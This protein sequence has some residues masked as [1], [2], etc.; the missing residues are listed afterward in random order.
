MQTLFAITEMKA[1]NDAE[2]CERIFEHFQKEF[3]PDKNLA[4]FAREI[5]Q[6]V[7]KNRADLDSDLQ[8]FAPRWPLKKLSSIDRVVLEIGAWEIVFAS[9]TPI[10]VILNE[11]IEIAKSFGD[12]S[13]GKFI[14]AVLQKFANKKRK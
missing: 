8:K 14:N 12:D 13:A 2:K 7:L 11:C 10:P 6:G 9:Q 1:E 4:D 5:F 3:L